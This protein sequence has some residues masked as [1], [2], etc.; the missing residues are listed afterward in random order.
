VYRSLYRRLGTRYPAVVRFGGTPFAYLTG[1]LAMAGTALYID[2]SAGEFLR[3]LLAAWLLIWTPDAVLAGRLIGN[4]IRPV[5]AWLEGSR[6][7]EATVAAWQAGAGIPLA[8]ARWPLLY[9]VIGAGIAI[10]DVYILTVLDL[11]TYSLAIVFPVGGL[12]YLY[13]A[14]TRFLAVEQS[15]CPVLEDI[16]ENLPDRVD[17]EPLRVPLKWRLLAAL[18]AVNI[19]TGMAVAG[20][21]AEETDDVSGIGLALLGSAAAAILVSSWLIGFLSTS[22]VTPITRLREANRRVAQGDFSVRVPVASTDESGELARS[23]NE[24]VA[25]LE[26][27][28]RLRD[29]FGAY[30]DPELAERVRREGTDLAGEE[31]EVSVLFMDIRDFTSYAEQAGA[32]EVVARLNELYDE[33][34]PVITKCGGHANKFVGDGLLSV[35]GAPERLEDHADRAVAA[36]LEIAKVVNEK[37]GDELRVGVGVNSGPVMSGTI[38]GGGRLDFTVI[39]DVVNT[40]SRVEGATRDTGDDVLITEATRAL[41][42]ANSNRW[43]D[44]SA[45]PLKGKSEEVRLFAPA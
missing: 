5:R 29:A 17:L 39:G 38:G 44:R 33:V 4:R 40:A 32:R 21:S 37:F 43:E 1:V 36:A 16:A 18:P 7:E 42:S 15:L 20:F 28:E 19:I 22:I 35:F 9:A 23:F 30:V 6:G 45:L 8:L 13:W 27:R 34:V 26:E 41:L 25:G 14:T 3:L 11:P 2:M 12:I 10:W 31:V 24:M